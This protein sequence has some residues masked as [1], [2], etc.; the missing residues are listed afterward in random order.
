MVSSFTVTY[1]YRGL[2][3]KRDSRA[4]KRRYRRFQGFSERIDGEPL[5]RQE[6]QRDAKK[7][8]GKAIFV[9]TDGHPFAF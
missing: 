1:T 8:G 5:T 7:R 9:D 6:C 3:L 4:T 2:F